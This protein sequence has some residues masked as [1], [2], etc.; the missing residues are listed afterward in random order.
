MADGPRSISD[1]NAMDYEKFIRVFG[2]C[3]ERGAYIA[4]AIYENRPYRTAAHLHAAFCQFLDG[5]PAP[6]KRGVLRC[7]PDLAGSLAEAG[8]VTDESMH[9]QQSAGLL[10]LTS[11]E[12]QRLRTANDAYKHK[13]DFPFVVCARENKKEV[14]MTEI[15]QR[16]SNE[17]EQELST[18]IA[19]VKK[20][21]YY[22]ILSIVSIN[23]GNSNM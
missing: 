13:F 1:V 3:V 8:E 22:R 15:E 16:L 21:C 20:I 12:R 5:Q 2:N 18:G 9:E 6:H 17:P 19:E 14:I 10:T 11:T 23:S 7:H 4:A